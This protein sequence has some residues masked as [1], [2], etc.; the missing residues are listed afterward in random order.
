[1]SSEVVYSNSETHFLFQLT[2]RL[3]VK[4]NNRGWRAFC[5]PSACFHPSISK[6]TRQANH[7]HRCSHMQ[8]KKN[9]TSIIPFKMASAL[10]PLLQEIKFQNGSQLWQQNKGAWWLRVDFN[11]AIF[12]TQVCRIWEMNVIISRSWKVSELNKKP[13]KER[14]TNFFND[15][16]LYI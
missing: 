1:M 3:L 8:G 9:P 5:R 4:L 11:N 2:S 10:D 6:R 13:E 7:K 12:S 16:I 14:S 15:D